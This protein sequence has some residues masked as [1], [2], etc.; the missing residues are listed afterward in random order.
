MKQT[1]TKLM[2]VL[3]HHHPHHPNV[4]QDKHLAVK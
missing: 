2:A 4:E 1:L 3:E